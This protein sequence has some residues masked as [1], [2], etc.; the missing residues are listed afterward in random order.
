VGDVIYLAG[1]EL[2]GLWVE[3][4]PTNG[5]WALE[6]E[7][8][9]IFVESI[10][11]ADPDKARVVDLVRVVG[12]EMQLHV[13]TRA[14]YVAAD[15]PSL[16]NTTFMSYVDISDPAGDIEL[17][18]Q[19]RVPGWVFNRYYMDEHEGLFRVVTQELLPVSAYDYRE[20]VSLYVYDVSNP[21]AITRPSNVSLGFDEGVWAVRFDGTR[22]YVITR[23]ENSPLY[24]LDLSDPTAPRVAGQTGTPGISGQLIPLDERLIFVGYERDSKRRPALTL[25]DVSNPERPR[26]RSAIVIDDVNGTG[27]R[28]EAAFDEK[29]VTVLE[30]RGLILLPYSYLD[31]STL[32]YVDS[33]QLIDLRSARLVQ[34]GTIDHRGLIR[35]ADVLDERLWVLSDVAFGVYDINDRTEPFTRATLDIIT[36]QELLDLGLNDCVASARFHTNPWNTFGGFGDF[37]FSG[38]CGAVTITTLS[39]T[40]AGLAGLRLARRRR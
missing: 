30:D 23:A 34:R 5:D 4:V 12:D 27:L 11:I 22:G 31:E 35:R 14:V 37:T 8:P 2:D 19:F 3:D 13:S 33:L 7:G 16:F 24:V 15:D 17:R 39:L 40:V 18:G 28:T 36:D 25:Y 20:I 6:G 29:A 10:T 9:G 1:T 21:E 26:R 38:P 32:D